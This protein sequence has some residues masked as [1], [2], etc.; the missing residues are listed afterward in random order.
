MT[1]YCAIKDTP[2]SED[3]L[4][5]AYR[6]EG[7]AASTGMPVAKTQ[8]NVKLLDFMDEDAAEKLSQIVKDIPLYHINLELA[9]DELLKL[10]HEDPDIMQALKEAFGDM[11]F[12]TLSQ[13]TDPNNHLAETLKHPGVGHMN[14]ETLCRIYIEFSKNCP[15]EKLPAYDLETLVLRK[16]PAYFLEHY[17]GYISNAHSGKIKYS[18]VKIDT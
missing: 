7:G 11:D 13:N 3:T 12:P 5:P 1:L 14:T 15:T 8:D 6:N 2:D 10:R 18:A 17:D 9:V 4:I 16:H